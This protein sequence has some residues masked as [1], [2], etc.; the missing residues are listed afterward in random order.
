MSAH[1][2]DSDARVLKIRKRVILGR[3]VYAMYDRFKGKPVKE[4][5]EWWTKVHY[6]LLPLEA[7]LTPDER[8]HYAPGA[9]FIELT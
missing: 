3:L 4:Y 5:Q 9:C 1:D 2:H 6:Q 8:H 7:I